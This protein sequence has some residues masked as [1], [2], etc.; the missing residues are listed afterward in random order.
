MSHYCLTVVSLSLCL[1]SGG[2]SKEAVCQALGWSKAT[3]FRHYM[4][5]KFLALHYESESAL[6]QFYDQPAP[7]TFTNTGADF[8]KKWSS[9]TYADFQKFVLAKG[10]SEMK[11]WTADKS[12]LKANKARKTSSAERTFHSLVSGSEKKIITRK[13]N[14]KPTKVQSEE[15]ISGSDEG[16]SGDEGEGDEGDDGECDDDEM[17]MVSRGS[18][19]EDSPLHQPTRRTAAGRKRKVTAVA[20]VTAEDDG[21][22]YGDGSHAEDD[23]ESDE[24]EDG[25]RQQRVHHAAADDSPSKRRRV[26]SQHTSR[27]G[28][29]GSRGGAR[30]GAR[31][32]K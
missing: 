20:T 6:Q 5:Y 10:D 27:R 7:A 18:D 24:S 14:L 15:D 3:F 4:V 30:G 25:V 21:S 32:G 22:D 17:Q 31:G 23:D 2:A 1:L 16:G 26:L 12:N 8:R 28:R 9:K 19:E 29:G 13:K 11:S